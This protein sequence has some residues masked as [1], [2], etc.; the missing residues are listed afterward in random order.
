MK[1]L[2]W[3]DFRQNARMLLGVGILL[4]LPYAFAMSLGVASLFQDNPNM[5]PEASAWASSF[6]LASSPESVG[7]FRF[8]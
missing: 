8:G 4:L 7:E 5:T 6:Y 3:K 1:T 2:L